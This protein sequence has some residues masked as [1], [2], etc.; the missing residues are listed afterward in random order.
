MDGNGRWFRVLE[1]SMIGRDF[2][3]GELDLAKEVLVTF[4]RNVDAT[5]GVWLSGETGED[6]LQR[7]SPDCE[8]AGILVKSFAV[9]AE[10]VDDGAKIG[11]NHILVEKGVS[12]RAWLTGDDEWSS[13]VIS[14][15]SLHHG[16]DTLVS[17]RSVYASGLSDGQDDS[18]IKGKS[19]HS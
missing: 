5:D 9:A 17:G 4:A 3:F 2:I 13:P 7:S 1:D 11:G 15:S 6:I 14:M 8:S 16:G 19:L 12:P 18:V 10:V